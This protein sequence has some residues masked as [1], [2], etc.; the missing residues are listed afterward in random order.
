MESPSKTM[1]SIVLLI[2][3]LV[4]SGI[5]LSAQVSENEIAHP[6]SLSD[7]IQ[8]SLENNYGIVIS[9]NDNQ[10]AEINNSWGAAGRY[11]TISM[12]LG[13]SNSLNFASSGDGGSNRLAGG[14]DLRWTLFNGYKVRFTKTE[15]EKI[16]ELT[17]G[18]SAVVVENTIQDV[19]EAYYLALLQQER[20]Q[21]FEKVTELSRD[22][23]TAE[24]SLKEFGGVASYQVLQAKNTFLDDQYQLLNQEI[25][26]K[27][28]M[29]NLNYL[30]AV[31]PNQK[32]T[33]TDPFVHEAQD[34]SVDDLMQ[35]MQSGN[36]TL[37]NQYINLEIAQNKQKLAQSAF[38]PS[39]SLSTGLDDTYTNQF[40]FNQ[41]NSSSGSFSPYANLTLSYNL[42]TGGSRI[43]AKEIAEIGEQTAQVEAKEMLH[44]VSNQLL[45]EYDAYQVRKMQLEVATESLIAAELNLDIAAEKLRSG[46]IN[47]FNYR[48]I[49][50]IYLNTAIQKQQA[51]YAL[52]QSHT[53]LTRL[54]G[55]FIQQ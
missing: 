6:L 39:L 8:L 28:T 53:N 27:T 35:K 14:I 13:S 40:L 5:Q 33:L 49:Q 7:A 19:I 25:L 46:A 11:P 20:K 37:Q 55:G 43:R 32:W 50:L 29:C 52:I 38:M 15:L 51:I 16:E 26:V 24:E 54:T 31:D 45:N 17:K 18:Y 30:L 42:Y 41:G 12:D 1:K 21:V 10:I 34:F 3:M 4:L 48:D 2:G 44:L 9:G 22:R 36:K 47:S 23:F